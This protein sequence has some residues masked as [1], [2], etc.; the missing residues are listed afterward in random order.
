MLFL[1]PPTTGH[2]L[3]YEFSTHNEQNTTPTHIL[4]L[5]NDLSDN[6]NSKIWCHAAEIGLCMGENGLQL[7]K[8]TMIFIL[9]WMVK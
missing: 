5:M 9:E 6:K 8:D 4:F 2:R 3:L 1:I 7:T